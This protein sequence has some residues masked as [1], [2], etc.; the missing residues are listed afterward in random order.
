MTTPL[1]VTAEDI[2]DSLGVCGSTYR[3]FCTVSPP[4]ALPFVRFP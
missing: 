2:A 4:L 1:A 3:S